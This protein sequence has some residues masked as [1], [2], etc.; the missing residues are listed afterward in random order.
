[1][2]TWVYEFNPYLGARSGL[3]IPLVASHS[4]C[5]GRAIAPLRG[6]LDAEDLVLYTY[7][8]QSSL[9]SIPTSKGLPLLVVHNLLVISRV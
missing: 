9:D 2:R 3:V 1:M 5:E 7:E 8:S 4:S 6:L